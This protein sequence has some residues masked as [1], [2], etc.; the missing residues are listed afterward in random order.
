MVTFER[1]GLILVVLQLP[2]IAVAF[3]RSTHTT[4]VPLVVKA[5]SNFVGNDMNRRQALLLA[6]GLLSSFSPRLANAAVTDER[7]S[8]GVVDLD[9]SYSALPSLPDTNKKI[10]QSSDEVSLLIVTE[11]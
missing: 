5:H 6:G 4:G 1:Y 7:G 11:Q 2:N 3:P 10:V 8:F 9:P